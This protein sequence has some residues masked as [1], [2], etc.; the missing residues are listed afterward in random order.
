L[1]LENRR[2]DSVP[3]VDVVIF[4]IVFLRVEGLDYGDW[5]FRGRVLGI[6][7]S[8]ATRGWVT[9]AFAGMLEGWEMSFIERSG[10]S[11]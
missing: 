4:G 5:R 7:R 8:S 11:K 6:V 1:R 9:I 10:F 3:L 2:F